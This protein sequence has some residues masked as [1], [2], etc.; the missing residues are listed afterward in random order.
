MASWLFGSAPLYAY[1]D[2]G[3]GILIWQMLLAGIAGALF[4]VRRLLRWRRD[5][6][7]KKAPQPPDE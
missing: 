6:T 2:P 1:A 7:E 3:S 4:Y 5:R